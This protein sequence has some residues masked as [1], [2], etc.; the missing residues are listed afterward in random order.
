MKN[1]KINTASLLKAA[2]IAALIAAAANAVL[3]FVGNS[4][5][6]MDPAVGVPRPDGGSDPIT[7]TPVLISSV[8]PVF[9]AAG[10]L[11]LLN[12]FS[13]QPLRVFGII[14]LAFLI[15]SLSGPFMTLP[16]APLG[17]Q[18]WLCLMHVVVAAA[19]WYAF[20][21]YTEQAS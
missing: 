20:K 12:R 14:A 9:V 6:L 19:V 18:V 2:P 13:A 4:T 17:M 1:S 11:A 3:Y 5:G 8:L 16:A 10:L 21:R 7:L 15:F